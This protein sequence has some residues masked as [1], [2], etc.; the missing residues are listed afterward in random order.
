M[1]T[2]RHTPISASPK[3]AANAATFN[4]PLSQ[5]DTAIGTVDTKADLLLASAGAGTGWASTLDGS[6]ASG[7]KVVPVASTTGAA[8][9][10][11][12]YIGLTSGT[13]EVGVIDTISAGV[14]VTLVAN[15]TNTYAAGTPVSATPA[16]LAD[17]RGGYATLGGKVRGAYID[18]RDYGAKGD[19][20]TNDSA[21]LLAAVTALGPAG[22]RIFAPAGNYLFSSTI[23][24]N[25]ANASVI[26]EGQGQGVTGS[27]TTFTWTGG[28]S[29]AFTVGASMRGCIFRDLSINNTGTGTYGIKVDGCDEFFTDNVMIFPTVAFSV[30]AIALGVTTSVVSCS[31]SRTYLRGNAVGLRCDNVGAHIFAFGLRCIQN[32]TNDLVLGTAAGATVQSAHFYGSTFE[33]TSG[34]PGTTP[35]VINRVKNATFDGCYFEHD[36]GGY[37]LDIPATAV[38][39]WSVTLQGC[40]VAGTGFG[41]ASMTAVDTN[42]A[43]AHLSV[44]NCYFTN[45][46]NPS[47]IVRNQASARLLLMGNDGDATGMSPCDD[48]TIGAVTSIG[49]Y[50]AG[51]R[52]DQLGTAGLVIGI[53]GTSITKH[54]SVT[55]TAYDPASIANGASLVVSIPA[56]GAA[57][58]D[59]VLV[60]FSNELQGMSLTGYVFATDSV[61]AIFTNNTGAAKDLASGT[62][63]AD[64]WKH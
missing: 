23:A 27:A 40:F 17:A 19:G 11:P 22:G 21:A 51:A 6:A 13:H 29:P 53:G 26:I 10:M 50:A 33:G 43:A 58:G 48:Y 59:T 47:Y 16:E 3:A 63:R 18:V 41:H 15:L 2:L 61:Y 46:A 7:Q 39:A 12:V 32:T 57:L 55:R 37:A 38:L 31:F 45:Y 5:L 4:A 35:V 30:A 56:T 9:G 1:T 44:M 60:S 54:L 42:L 52:T 8:S 34:I 24:L 64:I 14:S 62:L 28:A 25:I 49:N 36:G 20:A